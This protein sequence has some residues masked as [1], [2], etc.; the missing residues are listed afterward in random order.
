[1]AMVTKSAVSQAEIEQAY[2]L[3]YS[4]LK[5]DQRPPSFPA[6]KEH[7]GNHFW[8]MNPG[9]ASLL[10][11]LIRANET[12]L[13]LVSGKL[14][15]QKKLTVKFGFD[16]IG[17]LLPELSRVIRASGLRKV[18]IILTLSGR[19]SSF[20]ISRTPPLARN[21]L[22]KVFRL[23]MKQFTG[24][25]R[26]A[27]SYVKL[28]QANGGEDKTSQYLFASHP[29]DLTKN[30]LDGFRRMRVKI[31]AW[32]VDILCYA[33]AASAL[34]QSQRL[35]GE[36]RFAIVVGWNRCRLILLAR[37]GRFASSVL[38]LGVNSFLEQLAKSLG[39]PTLP[40]GWLNGDNL[41]FAAGDTIKKYE[42]KANALQAIFMLYAPFAQQ[43]KIQ[44]YNVCNEQNIPAPKNLT[45]LGPG[46]RVFHFPESLKGDLGLG[47][48]SFDKWIEPELAAAA[49]AALWDKHPIHLNCVP[50]V[51]K[52]TILGLMEGLAGA[53]KQLPK[54]LQGGGPAL[55]G[56]GPL[57]KI[58][59]GFV[60]AGL[61]CIYPVWDRWKITKEM[62]GKRTELKQLQSLK[63]DNEKVAKREA[64]L[65]RKLSLKK[66]IQ[67]KETPLTKM[68]KEVLYSLPREIRLSALSYREG[69]VS[70]RGIAKTEADFESFLGVA[71]RFSILKD[72][73]PNAIRRELNST[74]FELTFK[75]KQE[76]KA[77]KGNEKPVSAPR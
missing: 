3:H 5:A 13:A 26:E 59:I 37:D 28:P 74:N 15:L 47:L 73:T 68:V 64:D 67:S 10:G 44:L 32:D 17:K 27:I 30:I 16:Q 38:P 12:H 40:K 33:R 23:Q 53:F 35:D 58:L 41:Q 63:E 46:A 1:M 2:A 18:P 54:P 69:T 22:L 39:Q 42:Q 19:P 48:L 29:A 4:K 34:W 49:G 36:T 55:V 7:G 62:E 24:E 21:L 43:I 25:D 20:L 76:T 50:S 56:Q 71:N 14:T 45:V 31:L 6:G 11:V 57:R 70:M 8:K 77:A 51:G 65:E 72:P 9:G 75:V 52:D 61:L 60:V 66:L